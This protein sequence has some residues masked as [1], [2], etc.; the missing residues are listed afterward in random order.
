[1][2]RQR[3]EDSRRQRVIQTSIKVQI[4]GTKIVTIEQSKN[5]DSTSKCGP[6]DIEMT[7]KRS[8]M[9]NTLSRKELGT[10]NAK[11]DAP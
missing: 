4:E 10:G 7:Y 2:L 1:M 6:E 8:N 3:E 5:Q 11:V 9:G